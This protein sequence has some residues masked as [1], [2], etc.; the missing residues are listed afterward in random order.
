M[1]ETVVRQSM[2]IYGFI[3]GSRML[4]ART[5][6]ER[7]EVLRRDVPGWY[8]WFMGKPLLEYGM[9]QMITLNDKTLRSLLSK[10]APKAPGAWNQFYRIVNP[11]SGMFATST[12]QLKQRQRQILKEMAKRGLPLKRQRVVETMFKNASNVIL[13]TSFVSLILTILTLGV[14]I[15]QANVWITRR[16]VERERKRSLGQLA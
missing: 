8:T 15:P 16:N 12:N 4:W 6:N 7:M 14:A 5:N 13:L 10:P 3:I 2:L 9:T 11:V 1:G